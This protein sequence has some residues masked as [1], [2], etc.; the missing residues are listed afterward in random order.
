[1]ARAPDR[2]RMLLIWSCVQRER[3]IRGSCYAWGHE[4][5][6]RES[7]A[8]RQNGRGQPHCP[9]PGGIPIGIDRRD[10]GLDRDCPRALA[11]R[12]PQPIENATLS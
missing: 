11:I 2:P 10:S 3:I 5:A 4:L 1:M 8:R 9:S 7:H 6:R 12:M